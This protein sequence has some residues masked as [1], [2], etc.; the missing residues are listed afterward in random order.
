MSTP[1]R[2]AATN[3]CRRTGGPYLE[4]KQHIGEFWILECADMDEV[5]EIYFVPAAG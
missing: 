2:A 3:D 1:N 4:T 5:R